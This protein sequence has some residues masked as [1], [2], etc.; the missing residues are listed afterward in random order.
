ML[1]S[2]QNILLGLSS[3]LCTSFSLLSFKFQSIYILLILSIIFQYFFFR[4]YVVQRV[5]KMKMAYINGMII[6]QLRGNYAQLSM[7]KHASNVVEG[8]LEF[9]EERDAATIIQEIMYNRNFV[10]IVQDTYGNYVVQRALKNCKVIHINT[11]PKQTFILVLSLIFIFYFCRELFTKC[12]QLLFCPIIHIYTAIFTRKG[13]WHLSKDAGSTHRGIYENRVAIVDVTCIDCICVWTPF[14]FVF[15]SLCMWL[16]KQF[17][18]CCRL[19]FRKKNRRQTNFQWEDH[20]PKESIEHMFHFQHDGA[21]ML[22][23]GL[24]YSVP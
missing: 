15:S 20:N 22:S 17:L 12:F 21:E 14:S 4:N 13:F 3:T 6:S 9:S 5:V 10:A 16:L 2:L 23:L 8:L 1:L 18:G 11:A 7:N 19:F 24:G